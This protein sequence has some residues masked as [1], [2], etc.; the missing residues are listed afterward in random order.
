MGHRTSQTAIFAF[1]VII[2]TAPGLSLA[3]NPM[4]MGL[5]QEL[6]NNARSY[7][8]RAAGHAITAKNIMAQIEAV[9]KQEKTEQTMAAMDTYFKQYDQ[10]RAMERK[11]RELYK[12]ATEEAK[13]CM[14]SLE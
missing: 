1:L 14:K 10:H 4:M 8:Q 12:K 9:A 5:C 6:V 3:D 2:F 7:E 13:H 11:Y